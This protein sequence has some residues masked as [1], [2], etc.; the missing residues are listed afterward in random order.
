MNHRINT[1]V[2]IIHEKILNSDSNNIDFEDI[3]IGKLGLAHS[4]FCIYSVKKDKK[5]LNKVLQILENIFDD[6]SKGYSSLMKKSSL[7]EGIPGLGIVLHKL[8]KTDVLDTSYTTQIDMITEPIYK[9]CQDELSRNNFDYFYGAIGLLFYLNEVDASTEVAH[10]VDLLYEHGEASNFSF[11]NNVDDVYSQGI[12][13]GFAHGTLAII[14][15]LINIWS[16]GI[17]KKKVKKLVVGA[18]DMLLQFKRGNI[19]PSKIN[20]MHDNFDYPSVFPYNIITKNRNQMVKPNADDSVYHFTNRLGWCNSDLSRLFLLYKVGA[21]FNIQNYTNIADEI[22]DEVINRKLYKDTAISDGYICHGSSGVAHIYK[23]IFNIT[24]QSRFKEAYEY[25]VG[26]TLE[27]M[28]KEI[29]KY[30]SDKD[31]DV[32]TGWLGPL[33]VLSAYQEEEYKGWDTMFLLD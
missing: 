4:C 16:K 25:W 11:Y 5:Y 30:H 8:I 32:L 19:D 21:S 6:L 1:I 12:N 17:K 20:I 26:V 15:V 23:K 7:A 2:S 27:Y 18:T 14:A 24:H 28:E 3:L 31:L 22:A 29:K 13:F 33:F 9:R 10:I